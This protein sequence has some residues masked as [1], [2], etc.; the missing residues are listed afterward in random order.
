MVQIRVGA[1]F[2]GHVTLTAIV[3]SCNNIGADGATGVSEA[4]PANQSLTIIGLR[5]NKIAWRTT[6]QPRWRGLC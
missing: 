1:G 2:A 4:L 3:L 6:V 5:Y